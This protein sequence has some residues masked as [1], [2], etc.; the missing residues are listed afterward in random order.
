MDNNFPIR[1]ADE[2]TPSIP[3][4]FSWVNNTN[5]GSTERQTLINLDFFRYLKETYGM[6]I[7]IYAWDAGNF[8][9][10]SHGYGNLNGEKFR[11]QYPE[12]YKN[13]VKKASE[14][15]IRM[16]LWGSPD[17]FGDTPEEEKERFDFYVHLCKDYHF[18]AFKLDGVCGPLRPE[19]AATYAKMIEEC[20]KYSPDLILL[21]HRLNFYEAQKYITTF[22]WNGDETYTDVFCHNQVTAPHSRAY[23][24]TRG[25]VTDENGN[26]LRLAEDHGVCLSSSLDYF[27]DELIY[28]AFGRCLI[29]APEIYGNP[30]FLKDTEYPRLARIYRL[31][32]RYA[33]ILV[34]GKLLPE[35]YGAN[36]VSRG[37][38]RIRFICTGNDSWKA[39]TISLKL[40]ETGL[41]TAGKVRV[42]L[43]FPYDEYIGDFD[44]A[45]TV[46]I[47]VMPFRACLIEIAAVTD[48]APVLDNCVY[49]V[50]KEDGAI[51]TEIRII[52]S[53]GG[54]IRLLNGIN[55]PEFFTE[56]A[57]IDISERVP[58][59]LGTLDKADFNVKNAEQLY[60]AAVFAADNDSLEARCIKRS[61]PSSIPEVNAAREEFFNQKTYKLRGCEARNMFD[62]NP[63]TFYDTQSKTYCGGLRIDGGCLR[64]DCGE[65]IDADRA[66]ITCYAADK[67]TNEV[68]NQCIP[69][70]AEFSADL[71]KWSTGALSDLKTVSDYNAEIVEFN[72]HTT[73]M[74]PGRLITAVYP[75]RG[76]FRYMRIAEPMDRIYAVKFFR[77]NTEIKPASPSANNL[78]AHYS[79]KKCRF[80][81]SAEITLP[82]F[83]EGSYLALA[84]NGEHGIEQVYACLECGA[85]LFGF[86]ERAS[87]YRANIWEH[88]VCSEG[89]NNTFYFPLGNEFSGKTIKVSAVFS[90]GNPDDTDCKVWLCDKH[91]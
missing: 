20:R 16:G 86:P 7:C 2:S 24:F 88:R 27:E 66:E 90:G 5:E 49:E 13:I 82:D 59:L 53:P 14:L 37:N 77:G 29:T 81:K 50:I 45:D 52:R 34:S 4:Y 30:W 25:N 73:Y 85:S 75:A 10:A 55:K 64:V 65:I 42:S 15:G 9:G 38:G 74:L 84:V 44:A 17:G 56:T 28:Q 67:E 61:G 83:K 58:E 33:D 78:M 19:K 18:A 48:S 69:V 32:Q 11:S 76:P 70:N 39:R 79:R 60:E 57:A 35:S 68:R 51:P 91:I 36:A 6:Q 72:V 87:A 71:G 26:L 23:T 31:H 80:V 46:E 43:R 63:E 21:N 1:G 47:N 12:G 62:G 3:Y 41:E 22:L 54:E 8:D 89:L 40:D